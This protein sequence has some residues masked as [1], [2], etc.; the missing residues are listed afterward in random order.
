MRHT[1][2]TLSVL[3]LSFPQYQHQRVAPWQTV[4]SQWHVWPVV[5]VVVV[6]AALVPYTVYGMLTAFNNHPPHTLFNMAAICFG[7]LSE[8]LLLR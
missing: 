3:T 6:L 2:L 8:I 5:V 4:M 7:I 1:V